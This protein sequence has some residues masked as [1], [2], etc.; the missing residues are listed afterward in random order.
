MKLLLALVL[1]L[2]AAAR[3]AAPVEPST[4]TVVLDG[5]AVVPVRERIMSFSAE[6]RARAIS[7][8]LLAM[9]RDRAVDLD[10]LKTEPGD[11]STDIVYRDRVLMTVTDKD[12]RTAEMSRPELAARTVRRLREAAAEY[13]RSHSRRSLLLGTLY[14]LLA[15]GAFVLLL[16]LANK[17]FPLVRDAVET[18]GPG[19]IP[20]LRLQH[21]ELVSAARIQ[22]ALSSVVSAAHILSALLLFYFYLSLTFSFFPWTH[23]LASKL[24][25][26]V[27]APLVSILTGALNFIPNL[28]F[29]AVTIVVLRYALK[30]LKLIADELGAGRLRFP[31]FYP[32]WAE[33]T[34]QI[35]RFLMIAFTAVVIFPYLPGSSSP[36]FQGISVFLGVLFSLG[37]G[38]AISN[39]VAGVIMTYMRPFSAGDRV[40][41][42]DTVGDVVERS[43]L[44]TRIRTIKNVEVTVPN[45][46]ILGS[47][48]VNYSAGPRNGGLILNTTVT[49]GYD[50]PWEKVHAL[51]IAAAQA[52]DG[53][54][55][56]PEPF[57]L[58]KE[59]GDFSI[60]YEIN[61]YTDLPN[62]MA[63]IYSRLHANI[64]D[65]FNAAGI[66]IMSPRF[67]VRRTGP[68]STLPAAAKPAA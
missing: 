41:I 40:K 45:S 8:R 5:A 31:G 4:A 23:G 10:Q 66:E 1:L 34:W 63:A 19:L 2:P 9:A 60:T 24:S 17:V 62:H 68:E 46:L 18:R 58:Q 27:L 47:H 20:S 35:L 13:R 28:I 43:L 65:A 26:Y 51:L 42:G 67:I 39:S 7:E 32:E 37:S 50:A 56:K 30:F 53:V 54:R 15:T 44:V 14:A 48:I 64:Q 38:S 6:D 16:G 33:P 3:A 21:I 12:A 49:I 57:V 59:L 55:A 36:A 22:D 11:A 29:I 61:A 52:T 25:G